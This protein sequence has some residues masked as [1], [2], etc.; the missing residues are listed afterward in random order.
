MAISIQIKNIAEIKRAFNKA[1]ALTIKHINN[2][3]QASIFSIERDSKQNTPVLTGNLRSS[4]QTLFG[5]LRGE[6]FPAANYA[7]FVHEGTRFMKARPFLAE[8]VKTNEKHVQDLFEK[9]VQ[10]VFDDIGREV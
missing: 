7:I 9:A 10:N 3:I 6:L 8:A 2:A 4:H 5:T 1:P